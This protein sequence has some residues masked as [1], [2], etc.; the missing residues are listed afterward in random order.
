M[1]SFMM[2]RVLTVVI[3]CAALFFQSCNR[4]A[5]DP[6]ENVEDIIIDPAELLVDDWQ[7]ET[8]EYISVNNPNVSA[9]LF[10]LFPDFGAT[11]TIDANNEFELA[12]TFD[13]VNVQSQIGT[14]NIDS[15]EFSMTLNDNSLLATLEFS[16]L[17]DN[18]LLSTINVNVV[19]FDF[20]GDQVLDQATETMVWRRAGSGSA[21]LLARDFAQKRTV[22]AK[23]I[24]ANSGTFD[25]K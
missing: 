1:K 23:E 19:G 14:V 20:N 16:L 17:D 6:E 25:L 21:N 9:N 15:T 8:V 22:T 11:L 18:Q 24:P 12:V 2:V 10:E 7:A 3:I 4:G 5:N 13:S